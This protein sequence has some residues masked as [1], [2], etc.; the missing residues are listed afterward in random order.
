M[1]VCVYTYIYFFFT[2]GE[3]VLVPSG[4]AA[5]LSADLSGLGLTLSLCMAFQPRG[6]LLTPYFTGQDSKQTVKSLLTPRMLYTSA[7]VRVQPSSTASRR[8]A[9]ASDAWKA[10]P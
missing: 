3:S 2:W 8:K 7:R 6:M 9:S 10:L 5:N 4:L 1:Y